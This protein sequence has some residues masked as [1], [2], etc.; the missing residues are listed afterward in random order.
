MQALKL[1][2][3]LLGQLAGSGASNYTVGPHSGNLC[4]GFNFYFWCRCRGV[5]LQLVV[6]LLLEWLL[7]KEWLCR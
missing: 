2:T 5:E 7:E 6:L 1:H 3:K 4:Y